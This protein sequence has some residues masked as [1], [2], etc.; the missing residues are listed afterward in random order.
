VVFVAGSLDSPSHVEPRGRGRPGGHCFSSGE[1][2][3]LEMSDNIQRVDKI[4]C[5]TCSRLVTVTATYRQ[6]SSEEQTMVAFECTMEGMCGNPLWDPCPMYVASME[7]VA[8]RR[9]RE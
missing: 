5:P 8:P 2:G 7:R 9:P 3:V 6:T 1:K 4:R